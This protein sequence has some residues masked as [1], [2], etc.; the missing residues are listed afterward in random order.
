MTLNFAD[1]FRQLLRRAPGPVFPKAR[2][3][4]FQKYCLEREDLHARD[5]TTPFSTHLME[6][7]ILEFPGGELLIEAKVFALVLTHNDNYYDLDASRLYIHKRWQLKP[8]DLTMMGEQRWPR[9]GCLYAQFSANITYR[10]LENN[11]LLKWSADQA[12][13]GAGLSASS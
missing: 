3:L 13:S 5:L 11:V 6:E 1:A 2:R 8:N 7:A 10:K 9:G 4:Y 12:I